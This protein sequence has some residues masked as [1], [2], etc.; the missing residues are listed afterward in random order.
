MS[1]ALSGLPVQEVVCAAV[2]RFAAAAERCLASAAALSLARA[3]RMRLAV[4]YLL[5]VLS[6]APVAEKQAVG[7]LAVS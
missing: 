1:G 7:N 6:P 4:I 5:A 3:M 2:D